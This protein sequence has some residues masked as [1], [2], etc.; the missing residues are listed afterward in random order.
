[1]LLGILKG[2]GFGVH[3]EKLPNLGRIDL[4]IEMPQTTY[5]LELKLNSSAKNTLNQILEKKYHEQFLQKGKEI[6]LVGVN[7]SSKS[8]NIE[9]WKGSLYTASG[10]LIREIHPS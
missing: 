8:R 1:M 6:A 5:I 10:E 3:G 7:F 2:L 9:G 4:V